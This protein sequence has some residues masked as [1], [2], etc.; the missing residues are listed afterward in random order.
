MS[1]WI[2]GITV[3]VLLILINFYFHYKTFKS[4]DKYMEKVKWK[5]HPKEKY[6]KRCYDLIGDRFGSLTNCWIKLPWRNFY[7]RNFGDFKGKA[8]TCYVQNTLFQRCLL[9]KFTKKEVKTAFDYCPKRKVFVHF[10][11]KV[12]VNGKWVDVDAYEKKQKVPFGKH[13]CNA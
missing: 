11:S 9:K 10:Y 8:L 1:W 5:N 12:K 2:V 6:V 13:L 7:Y 3:L 4:L